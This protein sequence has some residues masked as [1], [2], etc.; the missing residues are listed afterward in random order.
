[1]SIIN[2]D[3]HVFSAGNLMAS[4]VLLSAGLVHQLPDSIEHLQSL[5]ERFPV[6]PF[7][8]GLTFCIFLVGEEYIHMRFH[9]HPL[10]SSVSGTECSGSEGGDH[11]HHDDFHDH[12]R[13]HVHDHHHHH[14][15]DDTAHSH[16]Q[17]DRRPREDDPLLMDRG[18]GRKSVDEPPVRLNHRRSLSC[19]HDAVEGGGSIGAPLE[20]FRSKTFGKDHIHHHDL[21]HV[22]EHVHGSLLAAVILLGA[23]SIH[24]VFDGLAIGVS[25]TTKDLVS[26]TTAVLAHKGFAGYALGS[27]MVAAEMNETHYFVLV[28]VF[29]CSSVVGIALGTAFTEL[30]AIEDAPQQGVGVVVGAIKAIVAGTFL[31]VSIVEIGL[32]ELLV[33]RDSKLL[34]PSMGRNEM[35]WSKLA[36]FLFGYLA[37]SYLSVFF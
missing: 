29:A 12:D 14:H 28:T 17:H 16:H 1:M 25:A 36:A 18:R 21:E 35:Q 31:Y 15:D 32:K 4:G 5:S 10:I 2:V 34:G 9:G 20:S 8:A 30:A 27:S 7:V 19:S 33:C 37:M 24:S 11:H 6:A 13:D 22:A 26:V 3:E 23:L